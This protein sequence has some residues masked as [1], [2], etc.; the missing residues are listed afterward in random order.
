[1]RA[2]CRQTQLFGHL[3]TEEADWLPFPVTVCVMPAT[4]FNSPCKIVHSR[5]AESAEK[6]GIDRRP[7]WPRLDAWSNLGNVRNDIDSPLTMA[8]DIVF[9]SNAGRLPPSRGICYLENPK[10]LDRFP[11]ALLMMCGAGANPFR[12]ARKFTFVARPFKMLNDHRPNVALAT[13]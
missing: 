11:A 13:R 9:V 12:L 10:R 2:G 6:S 1:M 5:P 7:I 4:R 8:L 3:E